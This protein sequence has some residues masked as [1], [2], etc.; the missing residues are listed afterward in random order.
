MPGQAGAVSLA[1]AAAAV[2][3]IW[4]QL[5]AFLPDRIY[6]MEEPGFL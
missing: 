6:N 2:A 1:A 3:E 4:R 5:E